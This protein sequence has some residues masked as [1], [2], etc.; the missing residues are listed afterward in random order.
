MEPN[1]GTKR[2]LKL[3][4]ISRFQAL[5]YQTRFSLAQRL[6]PSSLPSSPPAALG[7]GSGQDSVT[8]DFWEAW[9][10]GEIAL[11]TAQGRTE[12]GTAFPCLPGT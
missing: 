4:K 3:T 9:G 12:E 5:H 2:Q 10:R 1:P 11:Q 8:Q 6:P 7:Q